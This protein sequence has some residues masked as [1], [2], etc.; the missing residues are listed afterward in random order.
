[1][2]TPSILEF[3][4]IS[5]FADTL[6]GALFSEPTPRVPAPALI[7]R[8][9]ELS[10]A[11]QIPVRSQPGNFPVLA[12]HAYG[13]GR[14]AWLA[15]DVFW[16]WK[17]GD[18]RTEAQYNA[19][20]EA[21][22]SWLAV[23]GKDRLETPVN[24][25]IVPMDSPVDLQV[26]ALGRDFT[27]RMDASV[28]AL[29]SGPDGESQTVRLLPSI[30]EPGQYTHAGVLDQPG[31]WQVDYTVLFPD[32]DELRETAWFAMSA[33]S[34]ESRET[35]FREKSLR[36]VARITGGTYRSFDDWSDLSSLP[37][38]ETIPLV[39]NRFRWTRTWP[40]LLMAFICF[41]LEW[42]LRRR[43]GLR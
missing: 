25:T 22:L 14:S 34:P 37:V 15:T 43:H 30:D 32:G 36:D 20:W 9:G 41:V 21:L 10:R 24:T 27:P 42:W 33:T 38:S 12:T 6:G 28:T 1:M 31:T 11:A 16:R 17:L 5:L 18:E 2:Q 39:E 35:A 3:D 7:G 26:R 8:P 23:G 13:A 19:F 29:L 40:F 4:G